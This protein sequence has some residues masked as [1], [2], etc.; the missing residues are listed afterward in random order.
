MPR[1]FIFLSFNTSNNLQ[2]AWFF[3]RSSTFFRFPMNGM[4]EII[5]EIVTAILIFAI[6]YNLQH[7]HNYEKKTPSIR[8]FHFSSP[9][10]RIQQIENVMFASCVCVIAVSVLCL[11][12]FLTPSGF[13]ANPVAIAS[14]VGG[15]WT[16]FRPSAPYPRRVSLS[17]VMSA[18]LK[19]ILNTL[20]ELHFN[21]VYMDNS[22]HF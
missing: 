18:F 14:T 1:P 17:Q 16:P 6:S 15:A 7:S 12:F 2:H 13:S 8:T 4:I 22:I 10:R 19:L 9:V 5:Y 21:G 11:T 20:E 3:V